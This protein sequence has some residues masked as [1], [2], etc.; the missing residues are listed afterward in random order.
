MLYSHARV[1]VLIPLGPFT[2]L[3]RVRAVFVLGFWFV[4]Q[5]FSSAA[6]TAGTGGVACW[7]HV[8]GFV[9]GAALII[10]F[11]KPGFPLL[12][13]KR[14]ATAPGDRRRAHAVRG[15]RPRLAVVRRD[16]GRRG[17][18]GRAGEPHVAQRAATRRRGRR[19]EPQ[20]GPRHIRAG[21]RH[22]EG[23]PRDHARLHRGPK[24][25]RPRQKRSAP[26]RRRRGPTDRARS[27]GTMRKADGK[28]SL[29]SIR[30]RKCAGI[31]GRPR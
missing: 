22:Q 8:G 31:A 4:L 15:H 29:S 26:G 5:L 9:A 11:R 25:L 24:H 19:G 18:Y 7:A 21:G 27:A 16:Q 3:I 23:P 1:L 30:L 2:Q 6:Q 14:G 10:V 13:A 12:A 28:L 20:T 17:R